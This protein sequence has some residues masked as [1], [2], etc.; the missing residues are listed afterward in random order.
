MKQIFM[1]LLFGFPAGCTTASYA[2]S[3]VDV[4]VV[5]RTTGQRIPVWSHQGRM[6]IAGNP[7]EKYSLLIS[8]RTGA[9]VLAV[10][11]VDGVNVITGETATP[12]QSGYVI[13]PR[14]QV[15]ISGWRKS[16]SEV[17]AF[18]F[19]ALPDSY[20][21]RTDRPEN[22]GVIG[23]AAFREI[24]PPRRPPPSISAQPYPG[25]GSSDASR[26]SSPGAP[27][28][29]ESDRALRK[30]EERLGTGHGERE[31]SLVGYTHFHRA[32][33]QPG[34][35]VSIYYDSR[36]NLFARGI[37]P[38]PKHAEPNPFPALQFAPDPRG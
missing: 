31:K 35:L 15:D 32:T 22:V 10:A 18:V 17:A 6:Y 20:A 24:R 12:A 8:N 5:S 19:T 34:Q 36:A 3:L 38:G 26:E 28:S 23:I 7:G 4:A 37:I 13:D 27:A 14:G 21:A 11:S 25:F 33:S 29:P 9:R 1:A 30:F 16:M 2:A